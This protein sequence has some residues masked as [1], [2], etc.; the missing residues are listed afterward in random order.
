VVSD[1]LQRG[2]LDARAVVHDGLDV[3]A[4]GRNVATWAIDIHGANGV[5]LLVKDAG[6]VA[7]RG[8]HATLA[9]EA[10][11][12]MRL[13]AEPTLGAS[14]PT[15]VAWDA[16]AGLL[17]L[18]RWPDA[19]TL[20]EYLARTRRQS[21]RHALHLGRALRLLHALPVRFEDAWS[22]AAAPWVLSLHEPTLA[23]FRTS[24]AG[25]FALLE[26]L[27]T[28]PALGAELASLRAEWRPTAITHGDL[29]WDN[30]VVRSRRDDNGT[31]LWIV[32]WVS[33]AVGEPAWDVG[34]V[35]GEYLLAW[36]RSIP[37]GVARESPAHD[38]AGVPLVVVQAAL[39]AFWSGYSQ[40]GEPDAAY[41]ER[42]VRYAGAWLVHQ[43]YERLQEASSLSPS[44]P[45]QL[46]LAFNILRHPIDAALTLFGL[47]DVPDVPA[48]PHHASAAELQRA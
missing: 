10:R 22:V 16:D 4:V 34:A 5:S 31:S 12:L 24:S 29:K 14:L 27:Q 9:A 15:V 11:A 18:E 47:P 23:W 1:L 17:A 45:R 8:R 39:R 7:T 38:Q 33:A 36:L 13:H 25:N 40:A 44:D 21:V 26:L 37:S 41:R 19:E 35:L 32:D 6:G 46:Q 3:R 48:S 20:R 30:V 42:A 2:L 28:F 43:A